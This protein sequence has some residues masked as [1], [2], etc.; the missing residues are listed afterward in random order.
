[1]REENLAS[2][3][4]SEGKTQSCSHSVIFVRN[5]VPERLNSGSM[6]RQMQEQ[7]CF[8]LPPALTVVFTVEGHE[9]QQRKNGDPMNFFTSFSLYKKMQV[10]FI[11]IESV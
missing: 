1:M 6:H 7:N 3:E 4:I 9:W 8:Q 2:H 10:L 5:E 11:Y